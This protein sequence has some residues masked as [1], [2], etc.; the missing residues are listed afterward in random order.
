MKALGTDRIDTLEKCTRLAIAMIKNAPTFQTYCQQRERSEIVSK[1]RWP[2]SM[3]GETHLTQ[4]LV[5]EERAVEICERNRSICNCA[6]NGT[7]GCAPI[8]TI[9]GKSSLISASR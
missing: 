6:R 4:R 7:S 3:R 5:Y 9:D 1:H 8:F 2:R